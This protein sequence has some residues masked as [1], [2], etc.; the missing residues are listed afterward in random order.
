MTGYVGMVAFVKKNKYFSKIIDW[1]N[2][3][4]WNNL[5]FCADKKSIYILL[6]KGIITRQGL[7]GGFL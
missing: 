2:N 4:R 3:P 6:I 5:G 1:I 7:V